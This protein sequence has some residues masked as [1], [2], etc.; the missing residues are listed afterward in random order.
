MSSAGFETA[1]YKS[2]AVPHIHLIIILF[3]SERA[4]TESHVC[5]CNDPKGGDGTPPYKSQVGSRHH[6]IGFQ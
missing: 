4:G 1:A 5:Q 6:H 3:R 2:E